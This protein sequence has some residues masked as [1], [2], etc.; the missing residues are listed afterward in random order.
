MMEKRFREQ[1]Q[2]RKIKEEDIE[3]AV[4][5]VR[6]FEEHLEQ[7]DMIFES[8]AL[9]ALKDY[10][11][12]L[13]DENRNTWERLVA[14]ARYCNLAK[15]NDYYIYF[16]SI[17]GARNVLPDMGERLA[18][19]A[20]EETRRKVFQDFT[21]PPLGSSQENYPRLTR[22][23]IEK[24]RAE[25]PDEK[26]KEVLTWNYHKLPAEAF[27]EKKQRFE[28]ATSIDE[29]LRNEHERLIAELEGC[30]KAG[31]LWYEQEITPEVLEFVR[32]NQEICTGVRRG[33]KICV[34]KMPYAPKQYLKEKDP[35][36]KRYHACHCPLVRSAIRD[37]NHKISPIFCYCSGGYEK[38][39]FDIIFGE[40][41]EVD[42]LE[43]A[44]KGDMRCRFANKIPMGKM[45]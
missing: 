10:V 15:K 11:S 1:L 42:L 38:F 9:E 37:G 20:G 27:K 22:R 3:F 33:D 30:M 28:K 13:I 41:V 32:D 26:C 12:L 29:Y 21:L 16:T 34:T 44:L 14:I 4:N 25:L 23:I 39:H 2:A 17:L 19:L 18:A 5:A 40:P 24:M 7:K 35:A 8:A 43:S 6:E 36:L 31:Q 45:K